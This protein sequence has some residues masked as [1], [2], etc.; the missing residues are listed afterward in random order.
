MKKVK[1][2]F[3]GI[4]VL[5]L[6]FMFG[7]VYNGG[8][9]TGEPNYFSTAGSSPTAQIDWSTVEYRT[10]M[11][12]LGITKP[13]TDGTASW[14]SEDLYRFWSVFVGQNVAMN[15]GA[16]VKLEGV[17]TDPA[18]GEKVQVIFNFLD[19]NGGD[20]LGAPLVMDVPQDQ[21]NT[22]WVEIMSPFPLSF[23]VTVTAIT[24]EFKFGDGATGSG[25]IDD[26]FIRNA[27]EGEWVGDFFGPNADLP[28]GWFT[29]FDGFST[30]QAGWSDAT[31]QSGWHS[32][33]FA[34][35][36]DASLRMDKYVEETELVINSDPVEFFNDGS[37]LLFSA[38]VKTDLPAGMAEL[39]NTDPSYAMGFTVTWHDGTM[40]ADGWGEVGGSDY[41]FTVAGDQSD[42]TLY[43]AILTPPENATQFSLRARYWHFFQGTTYWDDFSVSKVVAADNN[44]LN[45]EFAGDTPNYFGTAG[46]SPTAD[47][48]WSM[49]EYRTGMHSLG[50]TKANADG[51]ASWVSED[52][53]SYWSVFTGQNV[54]MNVGAWVKLAG[55][56]TDPATDDERVQV[57]FNFLDENGGDLLGAP[58]VMDVP[59]DQ[60]N[61]GWIEIMSP[62]PLSFPVTVTAITAEFKFGDGAT[63]SGYIDDFFIRN[64]TE[65]EWVGDF[66]G[67]NADLPDG[68]FTWFDGFSAGSAEWS[69]VMPQSGWQV[70]NEAYSGTTSLRMD[71]YVEET[72]LVVN[73]DPVEFIND[74]SDLIFSAYVKTDLP[75]GMAE[76]ANTDPSYAMGFTVT[77]HDGTMGADGWGEVGGTD[78][79]FTVAGDQADWTQYQAI[80]TPPE[81]ATQFSLR[82][83]YWHFFQGT[84][85]W[86]GFS[87]MKTDAFIGD[88]HGLPNA[89]FE[90]DTPNYFGTAGTSPT[91][92]AH[93]S[94]DEYRT[95]MHSLGITKPEADGTASWISEDLYRFWSVFTGQNVAMNVG[96]WVK[97]TGV[98]T[99]PATDDER[100]Q[101]IF[102]FLDEN[103]GDLL[104]APLI[105][106]V[107]QD[108]ANTGWVEIVSPFPL[109]FPVTV[110]AITAEFKF[111]DGATGSGYIDDFFIRNATEGEWVG[112]FFG[113]NADLPVGWF[114]W[115]DGFSAGS[116]EWSD[117][118]PQSGWQSSEYAHSGESSLRMD[119]YVEETEL[120]VNTDPFTIENVGAP[121]VISAWVKFNLPAGMAAMANTD[122]SYAAGFTVT[123]HDGTMGADGWGEVGGSDYRFT[124]IPSDDADWTYFEAVLVPPENATQY[125]LRAR[126]WHFFQGTTWWDDFAVSEYQ[127]VDGDANVDGDVN[128]GDIVLTVSHI[129]GLST[130][131]EPGITNADYNHDG[132]INILDVVAIVDL[133]LNGRY[134]N[135]TIAS[136]ITE[137]DGARL[138]SDG[139]V[140][141]VQLTIQ[142]SDDFRIN[143]SSTAM[144]A[145]YRTLG[146]ETTLIVI[147]PENGVLFTSVGDFTIIHALAATTNG[148]IDVGYGVPVPEKFSIESAY[149]NPFNPVVNIGFNMP[150]EGHVKVIVY[151]LMG[152]NVT[153]L[154]N[155]VM[156]QGY[157][158]LIWNAV[159]TDGLSVASGVYF[160][161]V[162]YNNEAP[163]IQKVMFLK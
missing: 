1:V 124:T 24:A 115:F 40:G 58:L 100:V 4:I 64:A 146:N 46:T 118:M 31:P 56:N 60:A 102:N 57:I 156:G 36:G 44:L 45:G 2:I 90:G 74:G 143:I 14:I 70:S 107:P 34:H 105:L 32:T 72:E 155:E 88:D 73:S 152:R 59:Q 92:D 101:V 123:W 111:G 129:L 78:Y 16:W 127:Y 145:N 43:Q 76:L 162:S 19:E 50:I 163:I 27:T 94:M 38:Y 135:A 81:N 51:T 17:N 75:L 68:W 84:T 157:Q 161:N 112:D 98:N 108:Q 15:V 63:G 142:H 99:D 10:G 95:G 93:W 117:A 153:T 131:G 91:A 130:I 67:P 106:D 5:S 7:Q 35:S 11:H 147:A 140:G 110:T 158:N 119:K 148:Y 122:P 53:Y 80:M 61:T 134:E 20:L 120:V 18:T 86:D 33:D 21:A 96:A 12:S 160:I 13:N 37:D 48:H 121:L 116:A 87:V 69:D 113:P 149:P 139:F 132:S 23:P 26:F 126:Y 159:N 6:S 83:R 39:A 28:V 54:A 97:L 144:V 71:K 9:E 62:F 136:I 8:F 138:S 150:A 133:I 125:S 79:R 30:G 137:S 49:D 104:G 29:W 66:F 154:A 42:W 89:S 82:A 47:A 52:L 55:V 128:V 103:G 3:I 65:G 141:G 22:G 41:R 85:Y 109:S 77:W 114:T 25:Y 151:D